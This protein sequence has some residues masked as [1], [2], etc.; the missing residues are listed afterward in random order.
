MRYF[1]LACDYDGTLADEGTVSPTTLAAVQRFKD[2][3]RKAIL[4]TGRQLD[5][6]MQVFPDH[7]ICDRIVADNGA[8]LYSPASRET[9]ILGEPPLP[10]FL[11]ALRRRGVP[12]SVGQ[13]IVA[14]VEP[15]DVAVLQVIKEL[16]LE[17]HV[18]YNKGS[19][20][21]LPS[22][23]NKSTGLLAALSELGVPAPSPPA[24][25]ARSADS[26]A[27]SSSSPSSPSS[28]HV[29]I[30]YAIGAAPSSPSSPPPPEP[31]PPTSAKASPTSA[32]ACSS[33]SPPPSARSSAH[34][35]PPRP[36]PLHRIHLRPRPPL[37]RLRLARQRRESPTQK[38][39]PL[40]APQTPGQLSH[41]A[42][43]AIRTTSRSASPLGF[44]LMTVAGTLSGLLGIGSGA[45]KVIAMDQAMRLPFKVSTTTSNFMI[46][47]TAAASA[48]LY[49][50]AAIWDRRP[51]SSCP[52]CSASSSARSA[53]CS[54][55]PH[56]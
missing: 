6:L 50:R 43:T 40:A 35:S 53:S 2:S 16:G 33:K 31:P 55:S 17:L 5:D 13:V 8:V 46:G 56:P 51:P 29:D 9:K 39:D 34:G 54:S 37:L 22:G 28:R 1:A 18:I 25:S 15:Y 32:S 24:S 30:H 3:G 38:P 45:V 47:V 26:A 21:I 44:G 11:D 7:A 52:S 10:A 4:V 27:E 48:G 36:H 20:M 23:L 41:P 19:V 42:R 14:T 49:L 12:F